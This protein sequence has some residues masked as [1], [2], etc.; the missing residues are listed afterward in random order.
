MKHVTWKTNKRLKDATHDQNIC[1][2]F[3]FGNKQNVSCTKFFKFL[4]FRNKFREKTELAEKH[5]K[6]S[7]ALYEFTGL[8]RKT[9]LKVFLFPY[10]PCTECANKDSDE[11]P[12]YISHEPCMTNV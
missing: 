7:R 12:F 5:S 10:P 11:F 3:Y 8:L 2:G 1:K 9:S 6:P 4:D